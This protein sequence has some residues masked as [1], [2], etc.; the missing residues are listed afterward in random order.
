MQAALKYF[1]VSDNELTGSIPDLAGATGLLFFSASHNQLTGTIPS[2]AT[3]THLIAIGV[4]YNELSGNAPAVPSPDSL[5]AGG[6]RLCPNKLMPSDDPDWDAATGVTPWYSAC[7][8]IFANG[9]TTDDAA[10]G[11]G[12]QT[13]PSFA[14]PSPVPRWNTRSLGRVSPAGIDGSAASRS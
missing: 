1:G 14:Q 2:L 6:S 13:S 4:D 5:L 11:S 12:D 7:D 9:L 3:L 8:A 10:N